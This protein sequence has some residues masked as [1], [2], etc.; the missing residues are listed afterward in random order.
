MLIN[1][2]QDVIEV[3]AKR[4]FKVEVRPG[5]PAMPVLVVPKGVS[6]S[7]ANEPLMNALKAWRLEI[8]ALLA[9]KS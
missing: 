3:A 4:G 8:I 6:R 2:A 9:Q 5:P 1:N 7:L